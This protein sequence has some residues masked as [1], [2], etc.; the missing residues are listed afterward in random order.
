MLLCPSS[1]DWLAI[2]SQKYKAALSALP[3]DRLKSG[4][5]GRKAK[6]KEENA[7]SKKEAAA[8]AKERARVYADRN[9]DAD[10]ALQASLPR[11]ARA[12]ADDTNGRWRLTV[13]SNRNAEVHLLD[14]LR[15][16]FCSSCVFEV[17]MVPGAS[18]SV[19]E[20]CRTMLRT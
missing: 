10:K 20:A 17:H 3:T 18:S 14:S 9:V 1:V 16:Q 19:M 11:Q 4:Q 6:E 12:W 15:S 8:D 13:G 7:Q 5:E 2:L